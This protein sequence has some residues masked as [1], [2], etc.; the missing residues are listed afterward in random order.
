[1]GDA[2]LLGMQSRLDALHTRLTTIVGLSPEQ[3]RRVVAEV[4]DVFEDTVDAFI[5]R[6]HAELQRQ[7]LHNDA[8]YARLRQELAEGRFGAPALSDRQIRRRIYG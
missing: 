3:A 6:R 7:G 5:A 4:L 1:M 2:Y 8:I